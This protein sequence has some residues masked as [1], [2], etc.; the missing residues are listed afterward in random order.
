MANGGAKRRFSS[1]AL[2]LLAALIVVGIAA[3]II[4]SINSDR[5]VVSS[6]RLSAAPRDSVMISSPTALAQSKLITL[7]RGLLFPADASGRAFETPLT[8]A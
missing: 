6:S 2:V 1:V 8:K 7:E 3:P 4:V 5:I